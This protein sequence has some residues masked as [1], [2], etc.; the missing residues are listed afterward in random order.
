MRRGVRRADSHGAEEAPR[1]AARPERQTATAIGVASRVTLP[2]AGVA[3]RQRP[4]ILA[5]GQLRA[6][7]ALQ[8]RAARVR[9][10]LRGLEFVAVG[11]HARAD[12][13]PPPRS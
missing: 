7:L 12:V 6:E 11:A 9:V 13:P 5:R 8:H 4:R 1:D 3:R 10:Q 2:K